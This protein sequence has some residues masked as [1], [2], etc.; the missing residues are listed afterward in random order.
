MDDI[1][2]DT[3]RKAGKQCIVIDREDLASSHVDETDRER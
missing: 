1:I 3:A 2:S